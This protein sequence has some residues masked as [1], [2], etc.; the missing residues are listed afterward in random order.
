MFIWDEAVH[1]KQTKTTTH[2]TKYDHTKKKKKVV[3]LYYSC[4]L[5]MLIAVQAWKQCWSLATRKGKIESKNEDGVGFPTFTP[6]TLWSLLA[7][8]V[9]PRAPLRNSGL[10]C[11]GMNARSL[12]KLSPLIWQLLIFAAVV[13]SSAYLLKVHSAL[14]KKT[15]H[16]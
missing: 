3:G 2:K 10:S 6:T 4:F 9:A 1:S 15:Y 11:W 14:L 16:Q 13:L 8:A 12:R 5:E 7:F